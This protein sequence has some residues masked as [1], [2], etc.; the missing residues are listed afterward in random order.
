M[1]NRNFLCNIVSK[2]DFMT[3]S[4]WQ[5][6]A[7]SIKGIGSIGLIQIGEG[8]KQSTTDPTVQ[9]IIQVAQGCIAAISL[10]NLVKATFF[11]K[12]K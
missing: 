8:V 7:D 1:L 12:H 9:L 3:D 10:Y 11:T 4:T 2:S 6:V 5:Q